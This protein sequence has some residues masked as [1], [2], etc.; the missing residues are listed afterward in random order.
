MVTP[1]GDALFIRRAPD[2]NHPNE[3]D[4]PGGRSDDGETPEETALRETRE[5]IGALPYGQLTLMSSVE[6][7]EGVDFVTFQMNVLRRFTPKLQRDEHTAFRWAPLAN[8]P[9][10]L[11]PGVKET[12]ELAARGRAAQDMA[13]DAAMES[14]LASANRLAFDKA[15]VRS[16]DKDGRL[17]V[18][19]THI[20]K[21]NVCPYR[22]DEIPDFEELGLDPKR[23]YM[24]LRDP[25][26]LEKG[27][28]TANKI[29]VLN[30]HVPVSAVDHRPECVIGATGSDAVFNAPYLDQS[31]VIW[32]QDAIRG[33]DTGD[34][35]EISCAYYYRADMTPGT[36][37]GV[38]YDGVMRD[39]VFNHVAVV[40]KGRAGPD[41]MVG[42]SS[43]NL[44]GAK[45]VSKP[46]SKKAVMAK[47]ALLA[48]LKPKMAA[49]AALDLDTVLSGVKKRNWLERKPG[50]VAA[51]KPHLARDADIQDV[52]ELLDRL[53]GEQPDGGVAEDDDDPKLEGVL[54]LLRGKISDEDLAQVQTL[55]KGL[56]S[57]GGAAATP[58]ASDEPPQTPGAA[59]ANPS[60]PENK[61]AVPT[62]DNEDTV[63]K[64]AM[65]SALKNERERSAK[66]VRDVEQRTIERLRGIQE[67]ESVVEPYVGRLTAMDSAEAVYKSALEIMKVDVKDVHPSAYKAVLLA[68][69]KPGDSP[70][71]RPMASDSATPVDMSEIF[72]NANRVNG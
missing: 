52:V 28:P 18:A 41:V 10:P 64:A 1:Q 2:A 32:V 31:L 13:M 47:G 20:S 44:N 42:D 51:I 54:G 26:E 7:L 29:P 6:D 62:A 45:S 63:S 36:Y 24:L 19:L 14:A 66:A 21:A 23:I 37:E 22:G 25:D 40:K 38:P 67:A 12:I 8:P 15:S 69:P 9:Q 60:N 48:V 43:L 39:I 17:H 50:I 72:P 55:L 68:Q 30:V 57:G 16:F 71:Q 53:D 59:N 56:A 27:A 5:E 4:F 65:D 70:R 3:W 11:H 58:A 49:D 61:A 34:Q 33:I 35:Q 46:L